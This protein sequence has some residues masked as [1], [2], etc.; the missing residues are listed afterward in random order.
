MARRHEKWPGLELMRE[1]YP[2]FRGSGIV[3]C[4]AK[5]LNMEMESA[6]V[7]NNHWPCELP[8]GHDGEHVCFSHE[9]VVTF[10]DD[11]EPERAAF[12]IALTGKR[13]IYET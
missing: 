8:S 4:Q 12:V 3:R 7:M 13:F 11:T 5:V 9:N 6:F 1:R 2:G 10:W